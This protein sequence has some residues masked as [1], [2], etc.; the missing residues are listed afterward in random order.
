MTVSKLCPIPVI[1]IPAWCWHFMQQHFINRRL[2]QFTSW[3]FLHKTDFSE[4]VGTH[5][6]ATHFLCTSI[7]SK[8]N[9]TKFIRKKQPLRFWQTFVLFFMAKPEPELVV[10]NC[11]G[12]A[13]SHISDPGKSLEFPGSP[14]GQNLCFSRAFLWTWEQDGMTKMCKGFRRFNNRHPR[15]QIL[16]FLRSVCNAP[17]S[18][19]T[20][21]Q[22]AIRKFLC[23]KESY[24]NSKPECNSAYLN[25]LFFCASSFLP[26]SWYFFSFIILTVSHWVISP[27]I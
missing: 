11:R 17:G 19:K 15:K 27:D 7:H 24:H 6:E 26:S 18:A 13:S 4:S 12:L 1:S 10:P 25:H 21:P 20:T 16:V 8:L 22:T 5:N 2:F 3:L 9:A 14:L 23:R